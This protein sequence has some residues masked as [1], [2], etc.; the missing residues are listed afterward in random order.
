ME[1]TIPDNMSHTIRGWA[2]KKFDVLWGRKKKSKSWTIFSIFTQ[3]YIPPKSRTIPKLFKSTWWNQL[4]NEHVISKGSI[5]QVKKMFFFRHLL[6]NT[7]SPGCTCHSVYFR[8]AYRNCVAKK[9]L[10]IYLLLLF[11]TEQNLL[12][13]LVFL[14]T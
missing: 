11:Q 6:I 14:Q 13:V 7:W 4:V 9:V 10:F 1:Q 8:C 12:N 5:C 2:R 3:L